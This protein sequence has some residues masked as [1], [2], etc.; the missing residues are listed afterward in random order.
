MQ[1]VKVARVAVMARIKENRDKHR[2]IV[3]EAMEGYRKTA[4]EELDRMLSDARKGKR[5]AQHLDLIQPTDHTKDYD[6]VI[7]MMSMSTE[8]EITL[9]AN[10]FARYVRDEWEWREQFLHSNAMY[11]RT[12]ATLSGESLDE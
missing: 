12:A 7:D 6:R 4:I 3:L 9:S 11:S 5:I 10:D 2:A 8:A 1:N